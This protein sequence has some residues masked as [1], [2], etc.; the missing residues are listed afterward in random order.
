MG[1]KGFRF[2]NAHARYPG[3]LLLP[4]GLSFYKERGGAKLW[5]LGQT[6]IFFERK[7]QIE[8]EKAERAIESDSTIILKLKLKCSDASHF[9]KK[10]C[11][12]YFVLTK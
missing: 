5:G 1:K 3:L 6:T 12:N 2:E 7:F 11:S 9:E 10:T 8:A 4:L